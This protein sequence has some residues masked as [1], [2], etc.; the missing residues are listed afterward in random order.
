MKTLGTAAVHVIFLA[1]QSVVHIGGEDSMRK[2]RSRM[3]WV[4]GGLALLGCLFQPCTGFAADKAL[5]EQLFE[6]AL[7]GDLAQVKTFLEKGADVNAKDKAGMT[8]LMFA[9]NGSNP[10]A[11][12]LLIEKGADVNVKA[13]YG[14]TALNSSENREITEL[15]K[16]HGA[17]E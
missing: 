10:E 3:I 12:K 2:K 13:N 6:A 7:G 4:L 9:A 11:V 1:L 8:V 5:N 14:A 17:K 15:L 16:A